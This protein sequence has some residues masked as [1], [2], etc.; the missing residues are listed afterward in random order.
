MRTNERA[1]LQGPATAES[2]D[3]IDI[4]E[5]SEETAKRATHEALNLTPRSGYVKVENG[6]HENSDDHTY[7]VRIRGGVP[8]GC[9]CPA[10]EYHGGACKHRVA[11]ALAEPVIEAA[12]VR[13][14]SAPGAEQLV[15][16]G[17]ETCADEDHQEGGGSSVSGP[18]PATDGGVIVAG[19]EGVILDEE[20]DVGAAVADRPE[21]CQCTPRMVDLACHACWMAG[22][23]DP[24]PDAWGGRSLD[25][26][27]R[28]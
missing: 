14:D 8:V 22:F 12:D 10:D 2:I 19:D 9:E 3:P 28:H 15:T 5:F 7:D 16:D 24:N 11:V 25:E 13:T 27:D 18:N 23:E 6:S 1:G 4:L 26:R 21:D 20:D 17:G